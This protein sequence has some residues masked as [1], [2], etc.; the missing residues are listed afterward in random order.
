MIL[1]SA[2]YKK[3][4]IVCGWLQTLVAQGQKHPTI[5]ECLPIARSQRKISEVND[6]LESRALLGDSFFMNLQD[7]DGHT[8]GGWKLFMADMAL[9]MLRL[10]V[11]NQDLLIVEFSVAIITPNVWW[12]SFLLLPHL[13]KLQTHTHAHKEAVA[14][15]INT[16]S[17]DMF[18]CVFDLIRRQRRKNVLGFLLLL[19]LLCESQN[20][21]PFKILF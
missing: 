1:S 20:F 6:E 14:H 18:V 7:M 5:L 3:T 8:T 16:P 10:L 21:P 15:Q 17:V 12:N 11:L 13:T 4:L 9:E 19:F 2:S